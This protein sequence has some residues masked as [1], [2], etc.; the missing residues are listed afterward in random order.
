MK[1]SLEEGVR[2]ESVLTD[3]AATILAARLKTRCR[4]GGTWC[5]PSRRASKPG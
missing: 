4:S 3:E 2:A 5:A 1:A